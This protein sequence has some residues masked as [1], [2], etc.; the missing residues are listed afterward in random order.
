MAAI[1]SPLEAQRLVKEKGAL[2]VD[3]REPEEFGSIR[4]PGA[5]LEP[6]S[7]FDLLPRQDIDKP[8]IYFCRSG[9]RTANALEKLERG[10]HEEVYIIDGGLSNWKSAGLPVEETPGPLPL[11]RQVHIAAGGLVLA[12][13]LLAQASSAFFWITAFVG[14]GLLFSGLTG[15]C[16][17]AAFLLRMPWNKKP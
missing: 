14:A 7:V 15:K 10:G 6:L 11:M 8:R 16:G 2:L 12:S 17:M 5:R 3:V 4:I 9:R 13:L 1:I